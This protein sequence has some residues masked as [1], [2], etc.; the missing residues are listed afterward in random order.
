LPGGSHVPNPLELLTQSDFHQLLDGALANFDRV[1]IDT[2]PLLLVSDALILAGEVQTVVLVVKGGKTP[3][4]A[5]QRSV[6]LLKQADVTIG[7]ILLNLVP[8][9]LGKGHYYSSIYA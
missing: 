7:G 3:R 5:V 4:K 6:Q 8:L 9:R 2:A 1:I